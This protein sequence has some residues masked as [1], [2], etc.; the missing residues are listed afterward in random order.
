MDDILLLLKIDKDEKG[1][2]YIHNNIKYR[3]KGTYLERIAGSVFFKAVTLY[4]PEIEADAKG[5]VKTV[6]KG[7]V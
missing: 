7:G 3:E 1:M 6:K 2:Y 4:E 5:K